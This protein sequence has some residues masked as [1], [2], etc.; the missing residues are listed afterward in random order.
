MIDLRQNWLKTGWVICHGTTPGIVNNHGN[1]E[2]S[3]PGFVDFPAQDY[4]LIEGSS[5]IDAGEELDPAI[6]E[7]HTPVLEYVRHALYR[8]RP[9]DGVLDIGAYEFAGAGHVQPVDPDPAIT[10]RDLL[11]AYPNPCARELYVEVPAGC[12]PII[13]DAAGRLV[14][15]LAPVGPLRRQTSPRAADEIDGAWLEPYV[16]LPAGGL[17]AGIYYL[18]ARANGRQAVRPITHLGRP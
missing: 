2:G 4:E 12:Q 14:A 15:A 3:E 9:E 10:Q 1:V 6:A 16:W 18:S 8:P 5:C 7:L 17:P 13:V 11:R